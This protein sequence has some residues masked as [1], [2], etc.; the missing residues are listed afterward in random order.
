MKGKLQMKIGIHILSAFILLV[1]LNC[2]AQDSVAPQN[3]EQNTEWKRGY[4]GV[5]FGPVFVTSTGGGTYFGWG[6][7]VGY[8]VYR[9]EKGSFAL[10]LIVQTTSRSETIS[11]I[12][13]SSRT[14]MVGLE[15]LGRHLGGSPIYAGARLGM[16]PVTISA[17][18]ATTDLSSSGSSFGVGPVV[19]F[20]YE[21]AP[22]ISLGLDL[23]YI[24]VSSGTVSG[25]LGSLKYDGVSALTTLVSAKVMF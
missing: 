3:K 13:V 17:S 20:E 6:G 4:A 18:N 12:K 8:D 2:Y 9:D 11:S 7:N 19:G 22:A 25:D 21:V 24:S 23:S 15:I 5:L 10:G 14:T 16:V 1:T